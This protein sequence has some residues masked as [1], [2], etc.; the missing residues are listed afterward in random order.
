MN[1]DRHRVSQ[2]AVMS[3]VAVL[4]L[5]ALPLT[6]QQQGGGSSSSTPKAQQVPLS[7]RSSQSTAGTVQAT[8]DASSNGSVQGSSIDTVISTV[9]VTGNYKGSVKSP[10][11]DGTVHLT[12]AEAVRRGLTYNLGEV[13]ANAS[14]KQARGQRLSALA[15]LLPNIYASYAE[16]GAKVN[17]AAQGLD[18]STFAGLGGSGG[19]SSSFKLPTTVGP[20][21]YYSAQANAEENLSF[22]GYRNYRTSEISLKATE[23]DHLSARETVVLAV[24]GIYLHVLSD[25]A[26]VASQA[27]QTKQAEESY[28][29]TN[30]EYDA[31]TANIVD[32]NKS[33]IQFK[34]QQQRL[35]S[36]QNGFAK[37]KMQL[38]RLIG[39]PA[40]QSLELE[41]DLPRE[42]AGA[43]TVEQAIKLAYQE[44]PEIKS[45]RLQLEAAVQARRA[46]TAEYL[47]TLGI[48]GY[49]GLQGTDPTNGVAVFQGSATITLP[50]FSSGRNRADVAQADASINQRRAEYED[51]EG[52]VELD[53]RQAFEDL[54]TARQQLIVADGNRVLAAETL[55]QSIDRFVAG[56]TTYVEVVQSQETVTSAERDYIATLYTLNLA[57][58]SLA[59]ATGQAEKF[60]PTM[61]QKGN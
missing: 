46:A 45:A 12:L 35:I 8:T 16:N 14:L 28:K 50:I 33:L 55:Q 47:P 39:L 43:L 52:T 10:A 27:G 11:F 13:G 6:A 37:D 54:N 44:R 31:G 23:M 19:G 7:G 30:A 15:Q 5:Q 18:A 51:E 57:R 22:T 24:G 53:V 25:K 38:A 48:K 2:R 49:Y 58:V 56:V 40:G 59:R 29:Q 9:S 4:L 21:H 42:V 32:N 41:E 36:I 1:R 61:L 34:T 20:Y 60:V 17:L 3:M 26:N